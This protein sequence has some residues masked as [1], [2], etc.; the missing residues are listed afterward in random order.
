MALGG[1][2]NHAGHRG[3][4]G[5]SG[6]LVVRLR[7]P[8]NRTPAPASY[9]GPALARWPLR[10]PAL[11]RRPVDCGD[12]PPAG[13]LHENHQLR[14]ARV[15]RSSAGLTL[16]SAGRP[17]PCG[18][19]ANS[20]PNGAALDLHT[21]D[22]RDIRRH[23]VSPKLLLALGSPAFENDRIVR[24]GASIARLSPAASAL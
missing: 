22:E 12:F 10:L 18:I 6:R 7:G 23:M 19:A 3:H 8:V 14:S 17:G 13:G 2:G 24:Q 15:D 21:S 20:N 5:L 4:C 16:R 1:V 9:G 11:A